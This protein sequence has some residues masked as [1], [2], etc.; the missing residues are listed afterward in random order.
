[1]PLILAWDITHPGILWDPMG[2]SLEIPRDLLLIFAS[3]L[4][5]SN[6]KLLR[7]MPDDRGH[8]SKAF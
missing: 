4:I 6:L 5:R 7:N 3:L 1:M 2:Q 8:P